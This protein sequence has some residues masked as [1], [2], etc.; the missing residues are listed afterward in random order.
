[1]C[2]NQQLAWPVA[3][4]WM[5]FDK[6]ARHTTCEPSFLDDLRSAGYYRQRQIPDIPFWSTSEY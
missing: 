6:S 3:G 2:V 4:L 1:M 5:L